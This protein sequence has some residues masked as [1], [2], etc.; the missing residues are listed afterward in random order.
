MTTSSSV[1]ARPSQPR[2]R[3]TAPSSSSI[4]ASALRRRSSLTAFDPSNDV[5]GGLARAGSL[6]FIGAD[7]RIGKELKLTWAPDAAARSRRRRSLQ[8]LRNPDALLL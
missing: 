2:K 1:V 3:L 6:R 4:N 5:E 7:R 8:T